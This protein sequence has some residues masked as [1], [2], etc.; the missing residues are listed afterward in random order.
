MTRPVG[1]LKLLAIMSAVALAGCER[2]TAAMIEEINA[3]REGCGQEQ[4]A[5]A[6]EECIE[7]FERYGEM[8]TEAIGT[9]I[10]ALKA[11]DQAVDRLPDSALDTA[12]L[13]QMFTV[14]PRN[15]P[16]SRR[17][18]EPAGAP[19]RYPG[20]GPLDYQR[21]I[22]Q[23]LRDPYRRERPQP[24]DWQEYERDPYDNSPYGN[25]PYDNSPYATSPDPSP[26]EVARPEIRSA[27]QPRRRGVLRPPEERLYRPWIRDDQA[28]RAI[29]RERLP[30]DTL[31]PAYYPRQPRVR[32]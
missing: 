4:L 25:P 8:G 7:M 3:A 10:G 21:D 32:R 16:D 23:P 24:D 5:A 15:Y 29:P 1:Y 20:S 27:P 17:G 12:G 30:L 11:L 19:E 6:S 2:D 14:D 31:P 26:P 18:W 9:Y 28:R 13:G 22:D